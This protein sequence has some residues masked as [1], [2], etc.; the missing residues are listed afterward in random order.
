MKREGPLNGSESDMA[1][2]IRRPQ[3]K[4]VAIVMKWQ[5]TNISALPKNYPMSVSI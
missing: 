4:L 1:F 2:D 5:E 3:Q